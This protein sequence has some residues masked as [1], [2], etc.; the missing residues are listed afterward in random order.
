MTSDRPSDLFPGPRPHR[1]ER[2]KRPAGGGFALPFLGGGK[3]AAKTASKSAP[4]PERKRPASPPP[5][6]WDDDSPPPPEPPPRPP[7][8]RERAPKKPKPAAKPERARPAPR[9][10]GSLLGM[11]VRGTLVAGI[12][13]G[14]GLG[15]VLTYFAY[16]LPDISH[17]A[18]YERRPA[19]VV[20]AADGTEFARFGDLHGTV[21]SVSDLPPHLINAVLATED[22][23]FYY[24]FGVDPIGL[25][26]AVYVNWR[27][28][29][30]VQGGSTITQQ[31]AKNLFLSPERTLKR[32]IQE[33]LLALWLEHR[34]TKDEI[35][36]AYLNRVYLGAGTFGMDAAARTYFGK[37]ATQVDLRE[38][39]ILAGL[40]KAPSRYSPTSNPNEAAERAR[41]VLAAMEDAGVITPDQRQAA[42]NAPL[43]PPRKGMGDGR[44]F[45][46][47]VTD[48]VPEFVG[49]GHGDVV[50]KTTINLATQRAAE[51]RVAEILTG[52]GP[53][54]NVGQA[55]LVAMTSDG[56]IRALV[57]GRDYDSS[58][59]NRATQA[60]RQPGSAFKPFV[61]LAALESG[62]SPDSP[63]DDA[64][65]RI[66]T[67]SPGNYD[68]KYRGTITMAQAL[69]H[70]SNTATVRLADRVGTEHI[71]RVAGRLGI[72][73]PMTK[74]LSLA[75]GT[76]EVSLLEL[77][78]AYA[79]IAN[80][81]IPVWSYAITEITDRS[82]RVLYRRQGGGGEPAADPVL[83]AQLTRMMSGVIEFG[84]GRSAK[85]DRPAAAKTGTTQDYHDAWF[86]GF[87]ADLVAGVWMGNDNNREMKKITGGTLPAKLWQGF[88]ADAHKGLPPRPLPGLDG[89]PLPAFTASLPAVPATPAATPAA[90][91][92]P[93][94][95]ARAEQS[96]GIGGLIDRLFTAP[97]PPPGG[98]PGFRN[99]MPDHT[100]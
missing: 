49:S 18:Q 89:Q 43:A 76:S 77:T 2:R 6:A 68:G 28:G 48:L 92:A 88:M 72:V 53:A 55:A 39:A 16:D 32:K 36:A 64:P 31:L 3:T 22:R 25:A 10:R 24:H 78:G 56:A 98:L 58:E 87:T 27:S 69:A 30:S 91:A 67:W 96:A 21:H 97:A 73:S 71:R 60:R 20:L 5:S 99:E 26:R 40:L 1:P 15:A 62:L 38:A 65:V 75:L 66:G 11:L 34:F 52:P 33:A 93:R 47:W 4:K 74:D 46:D 82:G 17:V 95:A 94:G 9:R 7:A 54:A 35:L 37:P 50:V 79:G 51:Q 63:V 80:R 8:K 13:A 41:V 14:I 61:Y 81:G 12:W 84:T 59:F 29:R 42:L 70:S 86:V 45:A 83:V 57:G 19:V 90:V 23:R 100:R 85:L 44:Y